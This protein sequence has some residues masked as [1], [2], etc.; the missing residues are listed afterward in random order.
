MLLLRASLN[1]RIGPTGLA[2]SYMAALWL[3]A[4]LGAAAGWGV[5]LA[6][7]TLHP[8][9]GAVAVLGTYGVVFLGVAFALRIPELRM[10][11]RFLKFL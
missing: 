7:P 10:I 9:L 2:S 4:A 6:L 11:R 5:K 8:A 1:R 3:A